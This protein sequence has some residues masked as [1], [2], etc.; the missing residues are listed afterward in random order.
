MNYNLSLNDR[1]FKAIKTGVKRI[2]GRVPTSLDKTPYKD[3]K[4]HDTFTFK[5]RLTGETI[6]VDILRV[7]H[8]PNARIMLEQE[9]V[10][11]VLSSSND[12]D[13]GVKN[14]NSFREYTENIIK[15]GIYA[16]EMSLK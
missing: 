8:Y 2:E 7:S 11:D 3:I 13:Q 15:Y 16:I 1:P 12:I 4:P 5:N 10:N 6:M 9:G 14:F